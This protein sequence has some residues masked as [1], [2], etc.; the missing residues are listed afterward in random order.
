MLQI[1]GVCHWGKTLKEVVPFVEEMAVVSLALDAQ[2]HST[3][4]A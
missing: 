3:L 4:V 2:E 1:Q